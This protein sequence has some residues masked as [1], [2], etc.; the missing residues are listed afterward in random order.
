M[1]YLTVLAVFSVACSKEPSPSPIGPDVV[2]DGGKPVDP[3][4]SNEPNNPNNPSNPATPGT[5][6]SGTRL[7]RRIYTGSDGSQQFVGFFDGDR[8]ENCGFTTAADG[9]TRCLPSAASVNG[10]FFADAGCTQ[11]LV[12]QTKGCAAPTTALW[13]TT[14]GGTA[15]AGTNLTRVMQLGA[16]FSAS[17]LYTGAACTA[18]ASAGYIST[19]DLYPATSEIPA[20]SF[21]E[22]TEQKL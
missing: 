5:D 8:S 16:L 19:Y 22:A 9:K 12:L 1:R 15:C 17:T 11:P 18:A 13:F 6:V 21:V 3:T 20:T 4:H 2:S 14:A 7:K 10:S